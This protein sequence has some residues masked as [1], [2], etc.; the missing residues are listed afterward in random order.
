[1]T[2]TVEIHAPCVSVVWS[3]WEAAV[4]RMTSPSAGA[5]S[6]NLQGGAGSDSFTLTAVLTGNIFGTSGAN[7]Y[8]FGTNGQ[9]DGTVRGGADADH[10]VFAGGLVS[11]R[12]IGG[13]GANHLDYSDIL[14]PVVV[15]LLRVGTAAGFAGT[16]P[17]VTAGD[18]GTGFD[19]ITEL[20]GGMAT[21]DILVGQDADATW[22]LTAGDD[23]YS[24]ASRTLSFRG[25]EDLR[26]GSGADDF[27]VSGAHSGNLQ[28]GAGSDSFALTAV[29]SSAPPSVEPTV[30]TCRAGLGRTVSH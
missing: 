3:I 14:M 18:D 7:T 26:G 30:G 10:F 11:G 4:A 13:A 1:M 6:G 15:N 21:T 20:S 27:T 12:I 24:S 19:D 25:V 16:A 8:T 28:G 23:S 9:V 22:T 29:K 5:H 2:S 17:L